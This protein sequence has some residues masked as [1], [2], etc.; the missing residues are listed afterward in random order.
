M[1]CF[2]LFFDDELMNYIVKQSI[3]Y[4][5]QMGNNTFATDALELGVV[6]EVLL[7]C[8]YAKLPRRKMYLKQADDVHKQAFS[9]IIL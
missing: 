2:K 1:E 5:Q 7:L 8:G 9:Y 4:S 3:L 6:L